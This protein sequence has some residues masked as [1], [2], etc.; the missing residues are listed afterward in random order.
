[1]P[2]QKKKIVKAMKTR[3]KKKPV[4]K[5]ELEF[6]FSKDMLVKMISGDY[7]YR[8]G[9]VVEVLKQSLR[10]QIG[11]E[12]V[13]VRKTSAEQCFTLKPYVGMSVIDY[14]SKVYVPP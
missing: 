13:M 14:H 4:F 5:N 1:M 8:R 3:S 6:I 11:G 10:V 12:T 9:R 7:W 2:W